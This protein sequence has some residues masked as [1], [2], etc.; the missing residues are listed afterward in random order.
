MLHSSAHLELLFSIISYTQRQFPAVLSADRLQAGCWVTWSDQGSSSSSICLVC[1]GRPPAGCFFS[2]FH[3]WTEMWN[4]RQFRPSLPSSPGTTAAFILRWASWFNSLC[5]CS[6]KDK[7]NVS[8]V[9]PRSGVISVFFTVKHTFTQ[10][11]YICSAGWM[12]V[13]GL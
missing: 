3:A 8:S 4:L 1:S 11:L 13:F 9:T 6:I 7:T 2:L 5:H 10:C 12:W